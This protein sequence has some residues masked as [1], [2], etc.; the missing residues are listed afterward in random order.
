LSIVHHSIA[1][2]HHRSK[3]AVDPLDILA[4]LRL[5]GEPPLF[6]FISCPRICIARLEIEA[7]TKSVLAYR[8]AP[9][10]LPSQPS[11]V[12]PVKFDFKFDFKF[13]FAAASCKIDRK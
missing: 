13:Q 11:P 8:T 7:R 5:A 9:R 12:K 3:L 1:D 6:L 10:R 2:V 4:G